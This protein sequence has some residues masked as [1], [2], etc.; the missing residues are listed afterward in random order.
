MTGHQQNPTT[1][2]NIKGDPAGKINLEKLCNAMG[3]NRVRVVDPYNLK[4]CDEVL[5]EELKVAEPSVIISRRPCALLKNVKHNPPLRV[6][7]DK[8]IGCKSCMKIGCPA[9]SMKN[10]KAVVDATQ[11]VGCNVCSQLCPK[12]AF[13]STINDE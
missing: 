2:Y 4:E 13:V 11:C 8:C 12:K 6:E 5:K 9:I 10:G 7:S 1:G 3:I